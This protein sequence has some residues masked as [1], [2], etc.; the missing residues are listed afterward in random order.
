MRRFGLIGYPLGHSFSKAYFTEK[1]A[2]ENISDCVYENFPLSDI[3]A[4]EELLDRHIDLAGFNV[5][6]PYK[7]KIIPFLDFL[8]PVAN[9]VGA[10]NT[11]SIS[12]NGNTR[13]LKGFNTDVYGFEISLRKNLKPWHTHA[14]ILGTGGASKAVVWV[15]EKLHILYRFVSRTPQKGMFSY[16]DLNQTIIT[17]HLLIINCTPVGMYP[18]THQAPPIPYEYLTNRHFLYDLIYNPDKTL[19][20]ANA[21]RA[22]AFFCNGLEM[23]KLQA[24]KSWE[25]WNL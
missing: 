22:G 25:I 24:E 13:V 6:I 14:L 10:V 1:F 8:D 17:N 4:L 2:R 16:D 21:E 7:E 11:V 20:L 19:F 12:R 18:E 3:R 15:L 9:K 5:T 23:L